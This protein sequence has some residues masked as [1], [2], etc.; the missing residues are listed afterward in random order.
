MP[1]PVSLPFRSTVSASAKAVTS[2]NL[3]V[4]ISTVRSPRSRHAAQQAEHLVGLAGRQHRGRL[5]EDQEALVEIEL[6]EDLELL[7]L[8]GGELAHRHVERHA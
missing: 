2:R 7:L 5:V 6:L 3:W 4:I 1:A 8:A